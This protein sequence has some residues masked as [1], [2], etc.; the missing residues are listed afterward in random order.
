MRYVFIGLILLFLIGCS[1][2]KDYI[3][4]LEERDSIIGSQYQE[5]AELKAQSDNLTAQLEEITAL[6]EAEKNKPAPPRDFRSL[7][8]LTHFLKEDK[9]DDLIYTVNVFDCEQF[10]QALIYNA[11]AK[12]FKMYLFPVS[13]THMKC[14][15]LIDNGV[16]IHIYQVEPLSD[17][18]TYDGYFM[19][20]GR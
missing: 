13:K 19:K 3:T 1:P 12:G 10:A 18:I 20:L 9:T 2:C 7:D 17:V 4:A 8:E 5:I 16:V 15:A 14:Y 6:Y 11:E